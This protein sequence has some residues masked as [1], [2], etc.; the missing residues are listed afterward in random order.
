MRIRMLTRYS[1]R[2]GERLEAGAVV[3]VEPEVAAD[4]IQRGLAAPVATEVERAVAPG[5]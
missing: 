1:P 3:D 4:L 5:Q 2:R